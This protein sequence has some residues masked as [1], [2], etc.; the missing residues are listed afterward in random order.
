MMTGALIALAV[1][2]ALVVIIVARR[3]ARPSRVARQ[4]LEAQIARVRSQIKA[5]E[6]ADHDL[7]AHQEAAVR[8]QWLRNELTLRDVSSLEVPGLA[9]GLFDVLREHGIKK[10][11]DVELLRRRKVPGIGVKRADQLW[12][13][14]QEERAKLHDAAQALDHDTL[15]QLSGGKLGAIAE[16]HRAE[17][18]HRVRELQQRQVELAELER[19]HATL[20]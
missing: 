4:R 16:K 8:E 12:S 3:S 7:I 13:A 17:E 6:I 10:L 2:A 14:Y 11:Q 15:D 9:E 18:L 1:V 19:R 20:V 5:L